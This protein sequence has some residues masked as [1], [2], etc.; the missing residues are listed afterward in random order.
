MGTT[1]RSHTLVE[2]EFADDIKMVISKVPQPGGSSSTVGHGSC[3]R[4]IITLRQGRR[5][6][7]QRHQKPHAPV[8]EDGAINSDDSGR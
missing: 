6:D 8:R 2:E 4:V 3:A 5:E 7:R 1:V